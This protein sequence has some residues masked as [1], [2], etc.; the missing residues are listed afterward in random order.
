MPEHTSNVRN[1][2]D[3]IVKAGCLIAQDAMARDMFLCNLQLKQKEKNGSNPTKNFSLKRSQKL[4][5]D[6]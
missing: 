3:Q 5:K 4:F 1:A 6:L 2:K